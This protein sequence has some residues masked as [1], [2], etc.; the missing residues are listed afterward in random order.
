MLDLIGALA[1]SAIIAI[2]IVVLVGWARISSRA[3]AVAYALAAAWSIAIVA[4]AA[5]GGFAQ[6]ALGPIPGAVLP[7][8]LLV[9]GGLAAWFVWPAFRQALQSVPLAA[10]IGINAFRIGGV[11]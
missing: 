4:I 11:F 1:L 2:D 8:A 7:F 10:L 5:A 6:G 3:R 9:L